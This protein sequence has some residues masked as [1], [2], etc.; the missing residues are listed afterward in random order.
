MGGMATILP[1]PDEA[2]RLATGPESISWR[3]ASDS[4]LLTGA[5]T[6]LL[7]QVAHPT[8]AAGVREHSNFE[9]EPWQRLLRTLD[10]VYLLVYGGPDVARRIGA[11]LRATHKTIKGTAPDGRRYHALEPEAYAWVHATLAETIVGAHE[12]FGR[13]A[14]RAT[15]ERFWSEWRGLGRL[16]GVRERD[17]PE[18]WAEFDGYMERMIAERLVDNDVV[19]TVLRTLTS[20]KAPPLPV[21]GGRAWPVVAFPASQGMRLSTVGLLRPSARRKLGLSWSPG[22]ERALRTLGAIGR[23]LT[24]VMPAALRVPGPRYLQMRG[25]AIDRGP[26]TRVELPAAA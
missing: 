25:Q 22:Q 5:G 17:M 9:Q 19:H 4:R 8:V 20:P 7:L 16:L 1:S 18:S 13:P 3:W 14:P 26:F 15:V 24:P 2:A 23:S 12:R 10:Y 11:Q 6:A 21:L